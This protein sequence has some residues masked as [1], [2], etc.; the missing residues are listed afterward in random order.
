MD[1]LIAHAMEPAPSFTKIG[2]ANWVP[3]SIE[4]VVQA[5]LAKQPAQR[6]ANAREL[7]ERYETALAHEEGLQQYARPGEP[8]RNGGGRAPGAT[9]P[10]VP[11]PADPHSIVHEFDAWMPEKIAAYKLRGFVHDAGGEHALCHDLAPGGPTS[12][13]RRRQCRSGKPGWSSFCDAGRG[14]RGR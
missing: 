5:C 3:P 10:P 4:A 8:S 13:D 14:S 12:A 2:A 6:P 1:V 7:S 11:T 9:R